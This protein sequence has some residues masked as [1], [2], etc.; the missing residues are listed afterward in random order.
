MKPNTKTMMKWSD[1]ELAEKL[2]QAETPDE[3]F[4]NGNYIKAL[5][6]EKARRQKIDFENLNK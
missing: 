2:L 5:R 4:S 1:E 6:Q 3:R